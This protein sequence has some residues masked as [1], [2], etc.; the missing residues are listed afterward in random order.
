M[1]AVGAPST[2]RKIFKRINTEN[3]QKQQ[4]IFLRNFYQFLANFCHFFARNFPQ[5]VT[6]VS[7]MPERSPI[8]FN[9]TRTSDSG[10]TS[11]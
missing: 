9:S 5:G 1:G 10:K 6:I 8:N 11:S 4:H 2:T 7:K 3:V